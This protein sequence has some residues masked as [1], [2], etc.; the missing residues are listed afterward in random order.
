MTVIAAEQLLTSKCRPC[1]GGVEKFTPDEAATQVKALAGW[2][3]S[4]DGQ[5][6]E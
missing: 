2:R 5:R 3:L 6:I 1:E 4:R